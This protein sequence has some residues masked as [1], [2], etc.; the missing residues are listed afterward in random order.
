MIRSGF[1]NSDLH[2]QLD[3]LIWAWL[4]AVPVLIF[5]AVM[6][7]NLPF[8][9]PFSGSYGNAP[10]PGGG[11]GE[12]VVRYDGAERSLPMQSSEVELQVA[13]MLV[14]GKTV[15]TYLNTTDR[16]IEAVYRFPLPER[17]SVHAMEMRI[18]ERRIVSAVREKE[19]AN[20]I[21]QTA[22]SEGR[23]AAK[24]DQDRPNLFTTSAANINPGER[25]TVVLEY[26]QELEWEDGR[27]RLVYPLTYTPRYG[28]I[29]G[30][31][32][33]H[34]GLHG[35]TAPQVELTARIDAGLA[36]EFAESRSHPV[37]SRW[38]GGN[39]VVESPAGGLAA[40]RDF[41]LEWAPAAGRFPGLASFTE[42]RDDGRYAM[43]MV[44]PPDP[45]SGDFS[46]TL[47]DTLFILDIS[48][49][50]QGPSIDAAKRSLNAFLRSLDPGDRFRILLFNE[51]PRWLVPELSYAE[52]PTVE[53]VCRQIDRLQADGGTNIDSA[54]VEALQALSGD[55]RSGHRRI[56]LLTD[57]AVGNEDELF[58]LVTSGL[59]DVRLHVLGIG[60]APNRYL[61]RK[62]ARF[63]R[64]L[65]SFIPDSSDAERRIHRFLERLVR[66]VFSDV[67]L[68]SAGDDVEMYPSK[69]PD[70]Y[71]GQPMFVSIKLSD[72]DDPD[73][74]PV[75][76]GRIA[77]ERV[78]IAATPGSGQSAGVG[79]RWARA[80][81]DDLM[82]R[83]FEGATEEEV[84]SDVIE[85]A[86]EF[87][88]V[89]RYTSMVAVEEFPTSRDQ[90][91]T[92]SIRSLY[93]RGS[94]NGRFLGQGG[95]GRPL[96]RLAGI[97]LLLCGGLVL[98]LL[99]VW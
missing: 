11:C 56:V 30:D 12:M 87:G 22:K 16:V 70:L 5:I 33:D 27:F 60:S 21:Y 28:G 50:M 91:E 41:I 26:L 58:H 17:A 78:E 35:R 52:S 71:L 23:K 43:L 53:Q 88:L 32:E 49:S 48:G 90:A 13:G 84:R 38:E 31:G 85:V 93:P 96:F 62:M 8:H 4:L 42:R 89:T 83:R 54:L 1:L 74:I 59:G 44:V 72:A 40:D 63:G 65:C 76:H 3:R 2:R 67:K 15:Q 64:G 82:D 19:E 97:G 86:L 57:G 47:T 39:L 98:F 92:C 6:L 24:V 99:R 14:H 20:L 29:E 66:P 77:G 46:G 95:T 80:R 36:L 61:M 69:L 25:M 55:D 51:N 9:L 94:G 45:E 34:A 68:E 75:L 37:T 73:F 81:I 18:G 7:G 10:V 79:V